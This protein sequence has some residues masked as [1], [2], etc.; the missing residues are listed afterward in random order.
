MR[1]VAGGA[2]WAAGRGCV[3]SGEE[4]R[5]RRSKACGRGKGGRGGGMCGVSEVYALSSTEEAGSVCRPAG[6]L[7]IFDFPSSTRG[8]VAPTRAE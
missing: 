3:W 1:A 8:K 7:Y 6:R 5:R 2:V 4:G